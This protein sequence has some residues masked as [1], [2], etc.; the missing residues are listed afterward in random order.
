MLAPKGEVCVESLMPKGVEH[1]YKANLFPEMLCV[2]SL[3]PKGVEH[4]KYIESVLKDLAVL[5]L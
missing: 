4:S 5:N 1:F 3:M 2:E